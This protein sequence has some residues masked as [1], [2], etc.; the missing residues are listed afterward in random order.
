MHFACCHCVSHTLVMLLAR[1]IRLRVHARHARSSSEIKLAACARDN[2]AST[3]YPTSRAELFERKAGGSPGSYLCFSS[4]FS[5]REGWSCTTSILRP[6]RRVL[7]GRFPTVQKREN[8]RTRECLRPSHLVHM[9][10]QCRLACFAI[11]CTRT[12]DHCH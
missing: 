9:Q 1:V 8:N 11:T 2:P 7:H 4:L 3:A 6:L 12:A 5:R 10:C